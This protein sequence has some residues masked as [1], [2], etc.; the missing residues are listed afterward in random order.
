[1]SAT[2][3]ARERSQDAGSLHPKKQNSIQT[4]TV[5]AA[6]EGYSALKATESYYGEVRGGE[7]R[8]GNEEEREWRLEI[9][10]RKGCGS[11]GVIV[12]MKQEEAIASSSCNCVPLTLN[13]A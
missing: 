4:S 11:I 5:G 6:G 10:E 3:T 12:S 13:S 8:T 9:E 7:G 1:M 2:V